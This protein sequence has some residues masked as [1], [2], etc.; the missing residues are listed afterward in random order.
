M[1]VTVID[2]EIENL[3]EKEFE[4]GERLAAKIKEF[5]ENAAKYSTYEICE[6]LPGELNR[7]NETKRQ[8]DVVKE[9]LR[10]LV[11]MKKEVEEG[12]QG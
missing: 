11:W 10:M 3:E 4:L 9:K 5:K 7:I 12:V 8:L 1:E 2:R 6:F